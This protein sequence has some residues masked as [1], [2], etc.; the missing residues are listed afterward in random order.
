VADGL[1]AGD[2]VGEG[3]AE[4][5]GEEV[6]GAPAAGVGVGPAVGFEGGSPS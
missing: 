6:R 4:D 5:L 1:A 2:T 3:A